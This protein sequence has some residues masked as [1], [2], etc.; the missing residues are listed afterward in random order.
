ML[1]VYPSWS[2][3]LKTPG[4][5][6]KKRTNKKQKQT[7]DLKIKGDHVHFLKWMFLGTQKYPKYSKQTHIHKRLFSTLNVKST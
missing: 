2:Y 4:L 3:D 5:V 7:R 6:K 1:E